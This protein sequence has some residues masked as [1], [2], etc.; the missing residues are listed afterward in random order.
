MTFI[1]GNNVTLVINYGDC[2]MEEFF[3]E[4]ASDF[5]SFNHTYDAVGTYD[6]EIIAAN[7]V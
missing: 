7:D 1:L 4:F 6:V 3:F 2:Y 5:T